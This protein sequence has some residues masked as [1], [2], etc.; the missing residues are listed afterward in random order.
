MAICKSATRYDSDS[1]YETIVNEETEDVMVRGTNNGEPVEYSLGGEG[2]DMLVA[3]IHMDMASADNI[4]I[5]KTFDELKTAMQNGVPVYGRVEGY[6][7]NTLV[8]VTNISAINMN[9]L[10]QL[11][12]EDKIEFETIGYIVD[13]STGTQ[14]ESITQTTYTLTPNNTLTMKIASI[15]LRNEG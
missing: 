4:S 7:N 1:Y 5:D 14:I 8:A 2:S 10:A 15:D 9:L 12:Q 3:T 11:G 13:E 6:Y